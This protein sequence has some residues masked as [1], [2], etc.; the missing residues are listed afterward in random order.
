MESPFSDSTQT[1]FTDETVL[2]EEYQPDQILER[3]EEIDQYRQAL[4]GVLFGQSPNNI[5]LYGKAGLG[6]TAVTRFMMD[7]L[8]QEADNR[9]AADDLAVHTVNCNDMS[10]FRVV[11]SLV[12][13]LLPENAEQ[14]PRRGLSTGDAFETLYDELDRIGGVHY[15]VFDEIDHLDLNEADRLLYE[16]PRARANGYIDEARVGVVGISNN[17]TFRQDLSPK[18]RDT[19]MEREITF[20]PYDANALESILMERAERA[21]VDGGYDQSSIAM[22]AALAAKDKGSA[23]QAIDLLRVGVEI[24]TE[25]DSGEV[26]DEHIRQAEQRVQRGRL[27]N[28]IRQQ[29]LHAQLILETLAYLEREQRTPARSKV[30][31]RYYED[32]AEEWAEEPLSSLKSIQRHLSDLKMLGFLVHE[33]HNDGSNGGSYHEYELDLEPDVVIETRQDIGEERRLA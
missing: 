29:T 30:I 32:I 17:Y 20:S 33:K 4:E 14:F 26:R 28:K 23:R 19:L 13:D 2:T 1:L 25:R 18:V 9:D 16:F 8:Q 7:A 31:Q 6:K 11:R 24:A 5:F 3:D 22:A 15:V 12:N 27:A 21:L 10:L